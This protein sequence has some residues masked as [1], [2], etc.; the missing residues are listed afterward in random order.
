[1]ASVQKAT[2]NM[3]ECDRP[4]CGNRLTWTDDEGGDDFP[5]TNKN[6][7]D[8]LTGYVVCPKCSKQ[9]DNWFKKMVAPPAAMAVVVDEDGNPVL[10]ED[11]EPIPAKRRPGRPRKVH[12]VE[13]VA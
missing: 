4:G 8:T 7:S 9:L 12:P 3:I 13:A 11:G 2:V 10:N 6:W 1:M 5:I